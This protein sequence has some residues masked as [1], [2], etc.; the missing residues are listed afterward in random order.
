[1]TPDS[2]THSRRPVLD[3]DFLHRLYRTTGIVVFIG[4][5][6]IWENQGSA[7]GL[8]WIAGAVLC[9]GLY[10][11]LELAV[12][13]F[14]RAEEPNARGFVAA[15]VGKLLVL[16]LVGVLL[17]WGAR[18]RLINL[19]WVLVGFTVPHLVLLLKLAG[20]AVVAWSRAQEPAPGRK[21]GGAGP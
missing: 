6:L 2:T 10:Y 14:I 12:R 19:I 20:Q 13:R 9:L 8:G 18:Q 16:L 21:D 1:M 3:I 17:A 7:A 4:A 5:L 15:S 11:L